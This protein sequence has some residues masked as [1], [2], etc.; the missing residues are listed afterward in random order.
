ML[1]AAGLLACGSARWDGNVVLVVIDT[2][3]VEG[4][5]F[6]GG[7]ESR[8]PFLNALARQG[9]VFEEAWSASS[10]TAPATASLFTSTYPNEHGVIMGLRVYET[11]K[12]EEQQIRLNRIPESLETLPVLMKAQGYRTF[13]ISGNLN[14][15]AAMGFSRG[16]DRF[17]M[18]DYLKG[19]DGRTLVSRLLEWHD[20]IRAS[21]PFF[22][23]V[24]FMDPHEPYRRH[25]EWIPADAPP[26]P[27]RGMEDR[28][29]YDS[30]IGLV[31][32]ELARLF[33]ELPLDDALVIV[34]SDHGQ[35]FDDHGGFGHGF[36]LYSELTRVPLLL[37]HPELGS[38]RVSRSVSNLDIL[39]TLRALL[40]AP[41]SS[42]DRGVPLVGPRAP[43]EDEDRAL[44]AMRSRIFGRGATY[45]RAVV[46]GDLKLVVTEPA[47]LSELYDLA[48]DPREQRD[49]SE[50]RPDD[51]R[52]LR[53]L[54]DEQ[55]SAADSSLYE[56]ADPLHAGP[57]MIEMLERLGYVEEGH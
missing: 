45:K 43:G 26:R 47:G 44:F 52:A 1:A 40:G 11:Q 14:V 49:L 50:V 17:E 35:E 29:A 32:Q 39:P 30:E 6:H 28:T 8:A 33:R 2:L 13:G 4:L 19:R 37:R 56:A 41:A 57:E 42:Q 31:D 34:T 21:Q 16:F 5:P 18:V 20:E 55:A 51:V 54:L 25:A 38:G 46:N 24:H 3:R 15:D 7:P 53:A 27:D 9:L 12:T 22:L 10:W 23:Y 48:A 36:Q